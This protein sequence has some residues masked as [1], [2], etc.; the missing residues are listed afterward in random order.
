MRKLIYAAGIVTIF[1]AASFAVLHA[2]Q[3]P[4]PTAQTRGTIPPSSTGCNG[5]Y[6]GTYSGS[7]IISKGQNCTFT[8]GGVTGNVSQSGG[9]LAL[10]NST[11]GGN[12]QVTNGGSFTIGPAATVSGNV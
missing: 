2:Q 8:A 1:A 9:N 11:V 5:T 4:Q 6:T 7:L 10:A 3:A 12:V